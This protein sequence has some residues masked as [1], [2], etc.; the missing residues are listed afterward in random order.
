MSLS[1]LSNRRL[2]RKRSEIAPADEHQSHWVEIFKDRV[3][4]PLKEILQEDMDWMTSRPILERLNRLHDVEQAHRG[5]TDHDITR[6]SARR[7]GSSK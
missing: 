7:P 3:T 2:P 5:D 4:E 6:P 1:N